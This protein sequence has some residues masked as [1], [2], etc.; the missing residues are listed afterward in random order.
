MPNSACQSYLTEAPLL[1]VAARHADD[2][3]PTGGASH[4]TFLSC[5]S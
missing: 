1:S 2:G 4:L 5:L 3:S